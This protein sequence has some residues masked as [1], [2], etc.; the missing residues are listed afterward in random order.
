VIPAKVPVTRLQQE[1]TKTVK[2][3]LKQRNMSQGALARKI[4]I[5]PKHVHEVLRGVAS[6]SVVVWDAMLAEA[7]IDW[8]ESPEVQVDPAIER[9]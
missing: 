1:L 9:L 8:Y 2:A 6:A 5:T 7:V 4:G 3:G